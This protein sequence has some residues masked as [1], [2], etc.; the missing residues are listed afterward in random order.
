MRNLMNQEGMLKKFDLSSLF[1]VDDDLIEMIGKVCSGIHSLHLQGNHLSLFFGQQISDIIMPF[2]FITS[3]SLS[4]CCEV[5]TLEFLRQAP[6]T[7]NKLELDCLFI[8]AQE[9]VQ[10]VPAVSNQLTNLSITNNAQLSKYDLVNILQWFSKLR[11]LNIVNTKHLTPGTCAT[12]AQYCS[13]LEVFFFSLNF[14]L[15]DFRIWIDLLDG[16]LSHIEFSAECKRNLQSYYEI[17][18]YYQNGQNMDALFD[19]LNDDDYD[20]V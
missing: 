9:F 2:K 17:A 3:L 15:R 10:F 14:Q 18:Q 7:L 19:E 1:F 8:S 20:D 12:I 16:D 5:Y 4:K 6:S 13:N 11:E